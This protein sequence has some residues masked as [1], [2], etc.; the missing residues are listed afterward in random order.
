[1]RRRRSARP[2]CGEAA[3]RPPSAWPAPTSTDERAAGR[4]QRARLRHERA[5]GVEAVGAAVERERAARGAPRPRGV[6]IAADGTY[7][8]L[9]TTRSKRSAGSS[10]RG[11]VAHDG[12]ST[13][14]ATP[15]RG[16]VRARRPRP[17]P[18]T[19]R[20]R[21]PSRAGSSRASAIAIAPLPGAEVEHAERARRA[22]R[23]AREGPLD[24]EL[25]LGARDQHVGV[26][27]KRARPEL[28]PARSD[29]RPARRRR[30][31]GSARDRR[32]PRARSSGRSKRR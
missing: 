26:T 29:A 4:E 5:I 23:P 11:P 12:P 1:M 16:D 17:P 27:A 15:A 3:P 9:L 32:R 30:A 13:R 20:R 28:A 25:R 19:R 21:R 7:G 10:A 8:G 2:C 14:A 24:H 6:A 31:G 22:R 18:A